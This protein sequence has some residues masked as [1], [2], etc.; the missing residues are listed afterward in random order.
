MT[1]Y[2]QPFMYLRLRL[3][4]AVLL[5]AA[6][7]CATV[8]M[9][10]NL[11]PD[12]GQLAHYA[13]S[14]D[15][16]AAVAEGAMARQGFDIAEATEPDTSTRVVIGHKPQGLFNG[17]YLRVRIA[18]DTEDLTAVRVITQPVQLITLGHRERAPRLF[19][20]M[21]ARLGAQAVGPWPGM[22]VRA[23]PRAGGLVF[24]SVVR[25]TPDTI[26]LQPRAGGAPQP[27]ALGD[28]SGVA[29]SRGSNNHTLE[30]MVIGALVGGVV[31]T[32][33]GSTS[34]DSGD[35]FPGLGRAIG[36]LVGVSAGSL[37]GAVIGAQTRTEVWREVPR[38]PRP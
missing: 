10:R 30:G 25:L 12:A 37:L 36:T 6:A 38:R 21:D 34:T 17:E 1:L 15:T 18:R 20:A 3:L 5:P 27:F 2:A 7:S 26:V 28:L 9:M 4:L 23:V 22:R 33:V 24:G 8:G 29:V 13:A 16:L 11:P 32:V 35:W 14:P 31:G 19:Q